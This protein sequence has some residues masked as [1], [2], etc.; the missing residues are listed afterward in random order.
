MGSCYLFRLDRYDIVDATLK[1][2]MARFVNHCCDPTCY[3]KIIMIENG[4]KKI[5]LFA[6]RAITANEEITYE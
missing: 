3:A 4:E 6:K 2:N 1:G 5:V